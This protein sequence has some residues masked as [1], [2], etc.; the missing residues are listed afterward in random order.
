VATDKNTARKTAANQSLLR[1]V[2][3]RIEKVAGK[4]WNP[5]FLCECGNTECIETLELSIGEYEAVR[6]SSLRFPIKP[7]HEHP[8]FERVVD[9]TERYVVVEKFGEAAEL[10]KRFDPR[11]RG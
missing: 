11:T 7:G 1:E 10:A 9:E 8:E 4:A 5:E 3:E 6:I 2:N